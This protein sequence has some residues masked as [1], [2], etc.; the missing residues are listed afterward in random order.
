METSQHNG[1]TTPIKEIAFLGSSL[2]RQCGIATYTDD[3]ARSIGGLDS[4]LTLDFFAMSDKPDYIY[5]DRVC[6]EIA[7]HEI[8][9][10]QEAADYINRYGYDILSVQHEYGIFGGSA[11]SYLLNLIREA[12]MP[13]VTTLHT[14]L[15]EPNPEQK[16]VMD[17]VLQLSQRVVVMSE[18]AI[19]FLDGVHQVHPDKID[20]IPHGIPLISEK[21]GA[22]FRHR[23]GISGPMILTFG[24]LSPDKGVQY[25][26]EA[27][28]KIID[29]Y[30]GAVYVI[31]GAT[32]PH[33]RAREGEAYRESLQALA[34]SLGV[35]QHVRFVNRFVAT[36]E[37]VEYLGAMDIY[38]TPYLNAQQIT[39]G[40]LAYSVGAGKAVIST[41][42]AYAEE[43]LS[44]GRGVLVPFR[45]AD[46]IAE[47]VINI[48]S[49]PAGAA[50]MGRRAARFGEKMLWPAV[51]QSYLESFQRARDDSTNQMRQ[52][53]QKPA[54]L[55]LSPRAMPDLKLDHLYDLSDDTGI[56][57]HATFTVPNRAEGY[58]VDDN[59][60]ALLL[61][62]FLESES[63]LDPGIKLLQS[64][65]L[66]FVMDA[67]NPE[68]ARFKNF[69]TYAREWLEE[70]G[71]EDS[72]GRSLWALGA[73]ANRCR[74]K[75]RREVSKQLFERAA[76]TLLE[77]T[78]PRT[79]AYGIIACEEY[80]SGFPHEYSIQQLKQ[81]LACR[82]WRQ[83]E[84][85]QSAEWP[86]FE[87]SLSYANARLCQSLILAGDALGKQHFLKVGLD[88]LQWLMSHQT[89]PQ[90]VFAPIGSDC[91]FHRGQE[92]SQYDQQPV[93]TAGAVSACLSAYKATQNPHW[94]TEAN[95]AFRWFLGE[96]MLG[97]SVYD[98]STGG[99]Y[100]GLHPKRVNR[101][102][103]AESTLSFLCALVELR[104]AKLLQSAVISTNQLH[105]IK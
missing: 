66:S 5:P 4:S 53:L 29:R 71:S 60:R 27:M 80:L 43:I 88:S 10:Y 35:D 46:A 3:L 74:D 81:S 38:I 58:C 96:N 41:P 2:P 94:I 6:L 72:H 33:L 83:Y 89:G 52:I 59:A 103:G 95:R 99:C 57:Q 23:L 67:Y 31:V 61:T 14:V 20:M 37:L 101:N 65:Y 97:K 19:E 47:A 44:E 85:N 90:G 86:W 102:Q 11:G 9:G 48:Q 62:A 77:T 79:W 42:Y 84:I 78:S 8:S 32:H 82:L 17:E 76:P 28:P 63:P 105:E 30:P 91:C 26:I 45:S 55:N 16:Q 56:L 15:R 100:D 50:E 87:Q 21:A 51:A 1:A 34:K 70:V 98:R 49:D 75:G 24:L 12:K 40:T 73:M 7:D 68:K 104:S 36:E 54:S 13:V 25:V 39:S 93:E 64:R 22:S 69:L 92:K 18:K